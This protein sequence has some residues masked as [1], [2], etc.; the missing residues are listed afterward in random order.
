[1]LGVQR[2]VGRVKLAEATPVSTD[3]LGHGGKQALADAAA[4]SKRLL[5]EA[6]LEEREA[7]DDLLEPLTAEET[8]TAQEEL[9]AQAGPM[10]VVRHAREA[11]KKGRT[12]NSRNRRTT[13]TIKYLSQFG[14]DPLVALMKIV[15]ESEEAMVERSRQIDPVKKQLSYGEAKSIRVRCAETLAPYFHGKQPVQVDATIRGVIVQEFVGEPRAARGQ[16][17]DGEIKGILA[18]GDDREGAE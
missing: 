5:D 3:P 14:P 9:G 17:I 15:G 1:M 6:A 13:D 7:Q 10:T 18:P 4:E 16:T 8:A 2:C 11:R 12:P